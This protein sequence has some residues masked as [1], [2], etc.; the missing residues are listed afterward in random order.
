MALELKFIEFKNKYDLSD[1]ALEEVKGLF[2]EAFITVANSILTNK[3]LKPTADSVKKESK[4][5]V[6]TKK[7][8]RT[9]SK[10]DSI[11][12]WASK[13]AEEFASE[14]NLTLDDFPDDCG[15]I[16]KKS[17]EQ[18]VKSKNNTTTKFTKTKSSDTKTDDTKKD[19]T[20]TGNTKSSD[21]KTIKE[22]KL[23]CSGIKK[24]GTPC[25]R[26]GTDTPEGSKK[27]YCWRCAI[28]WK[29]YELSSDSSEEESEEFS[30][31]G[32]FRD[33]AVVCD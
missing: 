32:I 13:I 6:E 25:S 5:K 1:D 33:L 12:K 15:K 20:K 4:P 26:N 18:L 10:G 7:E 11:K 31:N 22:S 16:T 2:N 21:T 27:S 3:E 30:D 9:E 8:P 19:D 29:N 24:D 17:I 14:N 28:E 23:M